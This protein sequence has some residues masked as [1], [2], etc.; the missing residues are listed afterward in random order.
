MPCLLYH[1]AVRFPNI[2]K[3]FQCFQTDAEAIF[4][5]PLAAPDSNLPEAGKAADQRSVFTSSPL[6]QPLE[7]SVFVPFV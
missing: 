4:E 2:L 1:E 7:T 6:R 3:D 5:P